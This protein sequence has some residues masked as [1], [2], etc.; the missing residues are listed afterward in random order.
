MENQVH[1]VPLI[2][3]CKILDTSYRYYLSIFSTCIILIC[4]FMITIYLYVNNTEKLYS[5]VMQIIDF[6]G[7]KFQT[8]TTV[9][10]YHIAQNFKGG[11]F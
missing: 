10:N 4:V 1:F 11:K 2:Y 7:M 6:I 3:P 9:R 8:V 5:T